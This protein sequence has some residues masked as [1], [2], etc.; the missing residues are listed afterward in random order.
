VYESVNIL[1]NTDLQPWTAHRPAALYF[2]EHPKIKATF[3][4]I[5]AVDR[6]GFLV[7]SLSSYGYKASDFTPERSVELVRMAVGDPNLRVNILGI[8]A[9]TAS[10]HVAEQPATAASP[11]PGTPPTRCHPPVALV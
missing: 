9:W 7:N 8:A 3:L 1:L 5:N 4:T 11:L 2:V 10:A 6:W